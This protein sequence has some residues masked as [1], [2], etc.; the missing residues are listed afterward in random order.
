MLLTLQAAMI[1]TIATHIAMTFGG[2][3]EASRQRERFPLLHQV[4]ANRE[5]R[6]V[7]DRERPGS[8][9]GTPKARVMTK[10]VLPTGV[11]A[12]RDRARDCVSEP[13]ERP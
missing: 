13:P 1:D 7:P 6:F 10:R 12:D 9:P 2:I 5:S 11:S 8:D 4:H 3:I